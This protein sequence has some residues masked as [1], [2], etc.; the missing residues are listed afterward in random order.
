[1]N[2]TPEAGVQRVMEIGQRLVAVGLQ[3]KSM[4]E[5]LIR[6]SGDYNIVVIELDKQYKQNNWEEN[7]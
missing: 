4:G 6:L 2:K 3:F 7:Q 1:V 5:E